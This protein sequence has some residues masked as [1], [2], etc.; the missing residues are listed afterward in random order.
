LN[1]KKKPI[2]QRQLTTLI[3]IACHYKNQ[4]PEIEAAVSDAGFGELLQAATTNPPRETTV[5]K[6]EVLAQVGLE[7][8]AHR[9]VESLRSRVVGGRALTEPQ[10]K[11]LNNIVL[12]HSAQIEDFENIKDDLDL[13]S[14]AIAEDNESA[15]LIDA[16]ACVT[17]WNEPVT[18]G[19]RVF[20]DRAFYASLLS[21][22]SRKGFLTPKQRA[23]LKRMARKYRGQI[24]NYEQLE[25]QLGVANSRTPASTDGD[26]SNA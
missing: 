5:R 23:A 20:D 7:E 16:L 3:R 6:L 13:S 2:S 11:A 9:F 1:D 14:S 22:F 10:V 18:R 21:H 24:R 15:P 26:P 4:V 12:A 25:K 17:K 19:K 8:S